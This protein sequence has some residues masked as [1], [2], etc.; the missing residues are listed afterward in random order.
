MTGAGVIDSIYIDKI[1]FITNT[2]T[3]IK[4]YKNTMTCELA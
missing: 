1:E 2:T 3:F 4:K